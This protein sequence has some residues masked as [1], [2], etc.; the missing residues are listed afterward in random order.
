MF[1]GHFAVGFAAKKVA[2]RTNLAWLLAAPLLLDMLWP[3][4]V[5]L[6]WEH[7]RIEPGNTVF[8]PLAFDSYPWSHSLAMAA[9]WA[10]V[11]AGIYF[12]IHRYRPGAVMI[13]LLVVSHWVLDFVTH[14]PD[15]PLYPGG[16][17]LLG[18]GLWNHKLATVV[19]EVIM[20][21][22]GVWMFTRVSE[23]RDRIGKVGLFTFVSLLV[24]LYA[25]NATGPP[26]PSVGVLTGMS[27][28]LWLF[29]PLVLWIDRHRRSEAA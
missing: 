6:G 16:G 11:M 20:L 7:V 4:F 18:L 25:G 22:L 2:P 24:L 3:V 26:P 12:L 9:V 21:A 13:W 1:I 15:M 23:A 8:T 17:P 14:R 19:V 29:F 5:L 28:A 27:V 10:S